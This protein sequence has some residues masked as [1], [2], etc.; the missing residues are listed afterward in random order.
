MILYYAKYIT[1][2][3]QKWKDLC[4]IATTVK[5]AKMTAMLHFFNHCNQPFTP[6]PVYFY[7]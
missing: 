5:N 6:F 4:L 2:V 3:A 1:F 7:C